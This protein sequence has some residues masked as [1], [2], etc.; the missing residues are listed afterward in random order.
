MKRKALLV[1]TVLVLVFSVV[2]VSAACDSP[3]GG[4]NSDDAAISEDYNSTNVSQNLETL[5]EGN[6]ILIRYN[7]SGDSTD[8]DKPENGTFSYGAKGNIY[9]CESDGEETYYDFSADDYF[10]E[11]NSHLD[12]DG[13]TV[14]TKEITYYSEELTKDRALQGMNLAFSVVMGWMTYYGTNGTGFGM[15]KSSATVAKRSCDKYSWGLNLIV[16]I[17]YDCYIDTQTGICLKWEAS[18]SAMGEGASVNFECNTFDTNPT[19]TLPQVS[20]ENTTVNG[21]EEHDNEGN[22]G[23]NGDVADDETHN[24]EGATQQTVQPTSY[25]NVYNEYRVRDGLFVD[26]NYTLNGDLYCNVALGANGDLY[27]LSDPNGNKFYYDLTSDTSYTFYYNEDGQWYKATFAYGEDDDYADKNQLQTTI[28]DVFAALT[29]V[30]GNIYS[31]NY[32]KTAATVLNRA[33]DKYTETESDSYSSFSHELFVDK[34]L[35]IILKASVSLSAS[36]YNTGWEINCI[37]LNTEFDIRLPNAV[38]AESV[39]R[40]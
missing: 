31:G 27:Y 14:W 34:E 7:I 11:Y 35:N 10:V 33:C 25:E 17:N 39:I 12:E 8:E 40:I 36:G 19:F 38:E 18:A 6:G 21:K 29:S 26:Y 9:Y 16:K 20:E 15:K 32:S 1:L 28:Y 2:L 37:Q 13:N 24:G 4:G 30:M 22:V 3:F 23:G 5:R